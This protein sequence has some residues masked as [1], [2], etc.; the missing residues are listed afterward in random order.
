VLKRRHLYVLLFAVP[1][2][3]ASIVAAALVLAVL[4]GALW[5]FLLGDDPWPPFVRTLLGAAAV[6]VGAVLWLALLWV[7]WAAG[8]RQEDRRSLNPAHVAFAV[9][10]TVVLTAVIGG[11]LTGKSLLHPRTD[12]LAC[13]DACRAEGFTNSGTSPRDSGDR[14]CRCYDAEGREAKRIDLSAPGAGSAPAR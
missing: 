14:S 1:A 2:L 7:A 11:H 6:L 3:L 8:K 13:A 5:L 4:A 12:S 10:A 9:G